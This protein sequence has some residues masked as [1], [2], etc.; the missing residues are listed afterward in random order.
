MLNPYHL[1]Y[2]CDACQTGSV[3]RS[4]EINRVSHSAV[5]QAI[6][7]LESVLDK[8]LLHHA[9]RRFDLTNE[10]R[11]L[12]Q[13]SK[14]LFE[15]FAKLY[16]VVQQSQSTI[17]GP[18]RIGLS[19]SISKGLVSET[20]FRFCT[21]YELV[22]P[23]V[24]IGNSQSLEQL[25]ESREIDLG[26]GMEDGSFVKFERKT[27]GKGRFVLACSKDCKNKKQFLVGDKGSEVLALR[28]NLKKSNLQPRFLEIQSWSI[29]ADL[30][31]SGLGIGLF[32]DF[33]LKARKARLTQ[34]H[35]DILLPRYELLAIFR[36]QNSL[37]PVSQAFLGYFQS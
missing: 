17:S 1:K 36:S 2:F 26:F 27:I 33:I 12:F 31:E 19:H 14:E 6:R 11:V 5:S 10:G 28:S 24:S 15:N 18:L 25:L 23:K 35:T 7:S 13:H 29:I 30:A 8:K 3:I 21:D 9:P 32:P 34:I 37:S 4:A 22:E 20:L 16:S